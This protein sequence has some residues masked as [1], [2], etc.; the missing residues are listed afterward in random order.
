MLPDGERAKTLSW[1]SKI[2]DDLVQ[3]RFERND[4][5]IALGG[6]VIGDITGFAASMYLRGMPFVQVATTLVA[7]VD[8]S[9]GGKTGVNHRQGKNLI[10]AFYQPRVVVMDTE[11]LQTLPKREWIAGLAEVIKY[12]MIAD[13][14]FFEFLEQRIESI[15]HME[16]EPV[17]FLD[18]TLL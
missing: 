14:S 6:G 10:G 11:T 1:A 3:R 2:L 8:S 4:V 9:V 12:G 16:S 7:Q 15:L 18:T 13:D 5:L 17:Q